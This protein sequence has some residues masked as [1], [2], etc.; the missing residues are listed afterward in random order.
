MSDGRCST[1]KRA[2]NSLQVK[3]QRAV[4]RILEGPAPTTEVP[5][6]PLLAL[7]PVINPS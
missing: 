3:G 7:E 4:M 2:L 5:A 1:H 6:D